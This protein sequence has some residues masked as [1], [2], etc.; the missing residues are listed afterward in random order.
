MRD[1]VVRYAAQPDGTCVAYE[2]FGTGP[3]DLLIYQSAGPID[4]LWDLPP[5]ASF[6][7]TLGRFA[8]V[9]VFDAP[10]HGASDP[11]LDLSAASM[12]TLY[13]SVLC[14][15]DAAHSDRVTFCDITYG[16]NGVTFAATYPQRVRSLI[17]S[18]FRPSFPDVRQASAV[19]RKQ[20]SRYRVSVESLEAENPRVAHDPLLRQW[21]VALVGSA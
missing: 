8:R 1:A 6:M 4:L 20:I 3:S 7:E 9:I 11:I 10:G 5:L 18:N 12:E 14:V 21:W 17:L 2:V 16:V 13:D 15:L 19:Q